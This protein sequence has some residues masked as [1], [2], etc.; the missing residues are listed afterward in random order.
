MLD[1]NPSIRGG[2]R[3]AK[4]TPSTIEK[5]ENSKQYN[6]LK[7]YENDSASNAMNTISDISKQKTINNY[8][9][10]DIEDKY[11]GD[12]FGYKVQNE[13]ITSILKEL[14]E[15]SNSISIMLYGE[16]I[17]VEEAKIKDTE[18]FTSIKNNG[19][20]N[21]TNLYYLARIL[22]VVNNYISDC[23]KHI[24]SINLLNNDIY[25]FTSNDNRVLLINNDEIDCLHT[26]S[27]NAVKDQLIS[28]N[29]ISDNFVINNYLKKVYNHFVDYNIAVNALKT[30]NSNDEYSIL[31]E[32]ENNIINSL[33]DLIKAI[34]YS[35]LQSSNFELLLYSRIELL[36]SFY[37]TK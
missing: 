7:Q 21:N 9:I 13:R 34:E 18:L 11:F 32:K 19:E 12:V 5:I 27:M 25:N 4:Y 15:I 29:F 17:T 26:V 3:E 36:K 23:D 33:S 1:Y 37:N 14:N 10:D 28:A 16:I 30:L 24:E 6:I 35:K 8:N 20:V 2:I 31:K 22:N